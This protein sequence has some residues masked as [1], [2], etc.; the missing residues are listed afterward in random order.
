MGLLAIHRSVI[1]EAF[2]SPVGLAAVNTLQTCRTVLSYG[3]ELMMSDYNRA[4]ALTSLRLPPKDNP[5][6]TIYVDYIARDEI[7]A[8]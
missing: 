2:Y 8:E 6:S 4:V 7:L 5:Q 1:S 3:T